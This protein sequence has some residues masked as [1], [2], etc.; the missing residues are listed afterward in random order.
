MMS[1]GLGGM[2]IYRTMTDAKAACTLWH[3]M[4]LVAEDAL[5]GLQ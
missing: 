5:T 4:H 1:K 3:S 2:P